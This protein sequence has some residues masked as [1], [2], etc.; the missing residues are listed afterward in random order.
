MRNTIEKYSLFTSLALLVLGIQTAIGQGSE[1]PVQPKPGIKAVAKAGK[2]DIRLRW[3]PNQPTAWQLLNKHGYWLE[4]FTLVRNG[5][6]L[7]TPERVQLSNAPI[8]P[9]PLENWEA[10]VDTDK[11]AAIAAQAIYGETFDLSEN[12]SDDIMQVINK[13]RE[14]EQRFSFALFAADMSAAVAAQSALGYVDKTVKPGEKYVYRIYSAAP[15]NTV[16]LDTGYVFVGL[17]DYRELPVPTTPEA[18][19]SD[20]SIMLKWNRI[21]HQDTYTA[22]KVERSDDGGNTYKAITELP[23]VNT[24]PPQGFPPQFMYKLDSLPRNNEEYFYRVVGLT[25]FGETGPPS[26]A[27]SGIGRDEVE[28]HPAISKAEVLGGKAV[29]L[30]WFFDDRYNYQLKGF[31]LSRASSARGKYE[32]VGDNI[33]VGTREVF[34]KKPATTNYYRITAI[35]KYGQETSSMP[36]LVQMIDSIP[37]VA[38]LG[39]IGKVDTTGLV[40]LNWKPNKEEDLLGYRVFRS[41]FEEDEFTQITV[42]PVEGTVFYD[43]LAKKSLTDKIFYKIKAVD[44]HYNPSGFSS[45]AGLER[46]DLTPPVPP[47]FTKAEGTKE[48]IGLAWEPSSSADVKDHLLYRKQAGGSGWALV[49]VFPATDTVKIYKDTVVG[50]KSYYEYT[51]IAVDKNKLESKPAQPVMVKRLDTGLRE[52]IGKLFSKYD[53]ATGVSLAWEYDLEG[54]ER[55]VVYRASGTVSLAPYGNVADDAK[56]FVDRG[57]KAGETY[58]YK[59]MAVFKDGGKSGM[60]EP[61]AITIE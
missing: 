59:V 35:G 12:Y 60:S 3:A 57:V 24:E 4:R 38:P 5:K 27:V 36:Y 54:V 26:E 19:Y 28:A 49:A 25:P 52:S 10:L 32:T 21:H 41:N 42:S 47:V 8:K 1:G 23:I 48:G 33:P 20:L 58:Q 39:L 29:K 44:R 7:D 22:Y 53:E 17:D 50:L 34:D 37:P 46:P 9:A 11:Y 2:N 14:L 45:A 51:M 43:T 61:T 55:F 18:E 16:R 56:R 40:T 31:R 6:Q 13:S 30:E 15:E